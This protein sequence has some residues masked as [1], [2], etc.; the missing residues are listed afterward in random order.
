MMVDCE[1]YFFQVIF[2][3]S[4]ALTL[5]DVQNEPAIHYRRVLVIALGLV[6][7]PERIMTR[8][9]V[10]RGAR[11]DRKLANNN[12][13]KNDEQNSDTELLGRKISSSIHISY[14]C[15]PPP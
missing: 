13:S 1:L 7:I 4:K 12:N 5:Q 3:G 11:G 8:R 15:Y 9:R 10:L 2:R 6:V 14:I